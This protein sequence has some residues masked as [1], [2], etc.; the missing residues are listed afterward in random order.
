MP[1]RVNPLRLFVNFQNIIK[2]ITSGIIRRVYKSHGH[3]LFVTSLPY[4]KINNHHSKVITIFVSKYQSMDKTES[5]GGYHFPIKK[6]PQQLPSKSKAE[7]PA[8]M[9]TFIHQKHNLRRDICIESEKG[10]LCEW[11]R[12]LLQRAESVLLNIFYYT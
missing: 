7:K 5:G 12:G 1:R 2:N 11:F 4:R 3:R 10:V 8:S 9:R 6:Y